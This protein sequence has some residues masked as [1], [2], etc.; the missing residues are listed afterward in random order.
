MDSVCLLEVLPAFGPPGGTVIF[1][2]IRGSRMIAD[3]SQ[4][5]SDSETSEFSPGELAPGDCFNP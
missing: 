2:R 5:Q 3:L 4:W 1:R